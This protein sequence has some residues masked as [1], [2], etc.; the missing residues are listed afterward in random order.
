MA[1]NIAYSVKAPLQSDFP[2]PHLRG[3]RRAPG[4]VYFTLCTAQA[5]PLITAAGSEKS[6]RAY[7]GRESAVEVG[8][9]SFSEGAEVGA[10]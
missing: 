8:R 1:V 5:A 3:S 2:G 7:L 10:T 6:G 9:V 4:Q